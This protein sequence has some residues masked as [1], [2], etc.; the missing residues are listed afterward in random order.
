MN[1]PLRIWAADEPPPV[2]T[3]PVLQGTEKRLQ[4]TA[5]TRRNVSR[6]R[7]SRRLLG[8][9]RAVTN[10]PLQVVEV[11]EDAVSHLAHWQIEPQL[12]IT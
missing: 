8:L 9:F 11:V 3:I 2:W 1:R 6:R 7:L 5:A 12:S 4:A 10:R